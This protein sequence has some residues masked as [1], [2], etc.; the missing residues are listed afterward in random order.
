MVESVPPAVDTEASD[1]RVRGEYELGGP[2]P[3]P[4]E[5][6]PGPQEW[7]GEQNETIRRERQQATNNQNPGQI[8]TG[9][10]AWRSPDVPQLATTKREKPDRIVRST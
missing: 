8:E 5:V 9:P 4:G 1:T 10:R 3:V 2:E 7:A 6:E